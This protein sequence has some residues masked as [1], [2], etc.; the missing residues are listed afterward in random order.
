VLYAQKISPFRKIR[1]DF[2]FVFHK[3]TKCRF[4]SFFTRAQVPAQETDLSLF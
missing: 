4:C 1:T 2:L 3:S